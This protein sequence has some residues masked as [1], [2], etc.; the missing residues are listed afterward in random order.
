MN[1]TPE[2]KINLAQFR[3]ISHAISTY[4]DIS[5]LG[6]NI[7]ESICKSFGIKAASVLVFDDREQQ[8]YYLCNQGLSEEYFAKQPDYIEGKFKEFTEGKPVFFKN[9]QN[10]E[11]VKNSEAA[12]KEGIVSM[13]SFPITHR[14]NIVGLLKLYN[15]EEWMIHADD[16]SSIMVLAEQF[17]LVIE[18]NGLKNFLDETRAIMGTLPLRISGGF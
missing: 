6:C 13:L 4:E 8:L 3:M 12:I 18:Y 16:Q 17:G 2:K 10:D 14:G 9:L 1:Y 7:C 15:N 5:L 11:R